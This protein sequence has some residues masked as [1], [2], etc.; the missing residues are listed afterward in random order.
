M[1]KRYCDKC[2]TELNKENR[3]KGVSWFSCKDCFKK[4]VKETKN[5]YYLNCE[6][7]KL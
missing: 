3:Q 4:F 1:N 7:L 5:N 6:G 2:K